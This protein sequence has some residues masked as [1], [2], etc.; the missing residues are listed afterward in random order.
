MFILSNLQHLR[1]GGSDPGGM[2]AAGSGST[3]GGGGDNEPIL[4]ERIRRIKASIKETTFVVK[5]ED[6]I[7]SEEVSKST[8][9]AAAASVP[10]PQTVVLPS[11]NE[12]RD[13]QQE[14]EEEEPPARL[15]GPDSTKEQKRQQDIE[16]GGDIDESDEKVVD[17]SNEVDGE[18]GVNQGH[19]DAINDTG[20]NAAGALDYYDAEGL[21]MDNYLLQLPQGRTVI[22]GEEKDEEEGT[23]DEE[24]QESVGVTTVATP[25]RSQDPP[26]NA[27][28][29]VPGGCAICLC[30][31][32]AGDS[33]S[34]SKEGGCLHAFHTDCIVPWL[35]KK[36]E[37]ICPCCRRQ[38][39]TYDRVTQTSMM[40][41]AQ[42]SPMN[43]SWLVHSM[44]NSSI[45][46]A[47]A[48]RIVYSPYSRATLPPR[49]LTPRAPPPPPNLVDTNLPTTVATTVSTIDAESN[50][51]SNLP[52]LFPDTGYPNAFEDNDV[53][54]EQQQQQ[55]EED[56]Q[57]EHHSSD[58]QHQPPEAQPT[59]VSPDLVQN[60]QLI[61][62]QRHLQERQQQQEQH[63]WRYLQ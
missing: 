28:R 51:E 36:T 58:Q 26:P 55:E 53:G 45:H 24:S 3:G 13:E 12:E 38:F 37:P 4:N 62:Q 57:D 1:D 2:N 30:A 54:E 34:W 25:S 52:P 7:I 50:L 19:T 31:Y 33:V 42:F 44:S 8:A 16:E 17:E 10:T 11:D 35:A 60:H 61:E 9:A 22:D 49:P 40:T 32:E 56:Q 63:R 21:N 23:G 48:R 6:I 20:E 39:C 18:E 14:E 47:A 27:N 15:T 41:I 46:G 43:P 59:F 5:P 29:T